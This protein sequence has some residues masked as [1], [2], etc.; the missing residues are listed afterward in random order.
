MATATTTRLLSPEEIAVQ[1]GQQVP[2]VRLPERATVFAERETRLRQLAAGHAMR[3]YLLFV[4][5]LVHGQHQA[6]QRHPAVPLPDAACIDAAASAGRP[7]LAFADWPRDPA[8]RTALRT[9]LTDLAP[10]LAAG[11]AREAV[12]RTRALDDAALERFADRLLGGAVA[13]L[14]LAMAPLVAAGLQLYFTHLAIATQAERGDDRLPPFGRTDD[15][16]RCPCCGS[17]PTASVN[18]IGGDAQG[19]RY[20]HCALCS[21]QWHMV[22]I[23]CSHCQGTKGIGY[24]G[25]EALPGHVPPA[26]GAAAGAVQAETCSECGHYLKILHMAK[27]NFVEPLADDLASLTLDLLVSETGLTRHG[28]NLMLLFGDAEGDDDPGGSAA[29]PDP[30]G[31]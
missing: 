19:Y 2:Y 24:Q 4:A 16:T 11:A 5:D 28:V 17:L 23:K 12:E 25:L 9:L 13:G 26:T 8:W 27:D 10:R 7:T 6:L 3:D 30:G 22:R 1:A 15:A 31:T 18:R 14:D 20:L 29:P 21:A